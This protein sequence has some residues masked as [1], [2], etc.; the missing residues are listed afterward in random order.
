MEVWFSPRWKS[1]PF[2]SWALYHWINVMK[3][4]AMHDR[5][6]NLL[7]NGSS[8]MQGYAS[9]RLSSHDGY[10]VSKSE[11]VINVFSWRPSM[12]LFWAGASQFEPHRGQVGRISTWP[13]LKHGPR[14]LTCARVWQSFEKA[15]LR[16]CESNT[17]LS[18]ESWV[19]CHFFFFIEREWWRNSDGY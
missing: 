1:K 5:F 6:I 15:S 13:V 3:R 7:S 11:L 14:S 4:G 10:L 12:M 17:R 2:V 8:P 9:W 16:R 19:I 18:R